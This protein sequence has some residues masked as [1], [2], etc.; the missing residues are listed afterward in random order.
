MISFVVQQEQFGDL[1]LQPIWQQ[2]RFAKHSSNV[3]DYVAEVIE[4]RQRHI[5]GDRN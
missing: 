3:I 2:T 4:L 5:D 1:Q